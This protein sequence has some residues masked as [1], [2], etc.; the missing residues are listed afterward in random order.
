MSRVVVQLGDV[1]NRCFVAMPFLPLFE[2]QYERVIRPAVETAGL[3]CV[4]GDEVYTKPLIVQDVWASIRRSRLVVAELSGRNPNVMYEVGLAHAIGKPIVLLTRNE[5]DVPFDLKALRYIY[6]DTD[7]PDWGPDL[8]AEL[9]R[10]IERVLA[11]PGLA[12]HLE[13]VL[14]ESVLPAAPLGPL[15]APAAPAG[16]W[17]ELGG[18]WQGDWISPARIHRATLVI[19]N[20]HGQRFT[21]SLTVTYDK[22][23]QQTIVEETLSADF[24][25]PALLSLVGINYTYVQQGASASYTLD[26]FRLHVAADRR[27]LTGQVL[28]AA[29]TRDIA[30]TRVHPSQGDTA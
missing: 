18:V 3:V 1:Q 22:A 23:G 24:A 29:G 27:Q 5:D 25:Q 14:D 10:A 30:F 17:P 21:A 12:A 2:R 6:Y 26:S 15:R 11:T 16:P 7:N 9:G 8:R 28:L 13:D 20:G 4:R 19:P